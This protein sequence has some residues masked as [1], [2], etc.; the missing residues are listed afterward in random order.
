MK[1][2]EKIEEELRSIAMVRIAEPDT[3]A[4]T[5]QD[6]RNYAPAEGLSYSTI[7]DLVTVLSKKFD[8]LVLHDPIDGC[9]MVDLQEAS[10]GSVGE[11]PCRLHPKKE[12]HE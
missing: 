7:P 2:Q 6:E 12:E 11:L 1:K 9:L 5:P 3:K 8:L 4:G 10:R